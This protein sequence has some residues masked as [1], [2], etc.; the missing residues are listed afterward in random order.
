MQRRPAQDSRTKMAVFY[1]GLIAL[2]LV[3]CL[4][5]LLAHQVAG[6]PIPPARDFAQLPLMVAFALSALAYR[7]QPRQ[8]AVKRL[9]VT[10]VATLTAGA[11]GHVVSAYYL[12]HTVPSWGWLADATDLALQ[13]LL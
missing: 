8:L 2:G 7:L 5:P 10:A 3:D 12:N 11:L 13:Q 9:L 4:A 1:L 6:G